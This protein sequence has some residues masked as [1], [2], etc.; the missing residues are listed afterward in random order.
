MTPDQLGIVLLGTTAVALSQSPS[1]A[2]RRFAPVFGLLGQPFWFWSAFSAHQP[3]VLLVCTL[4]TGAWARGLWSHWIA[5]WWAAR[6]AASALD[7]LRLCTI[8]FVPA[9]VAAQGRPP[10]RVYLAGPVTGV[11]GYRA[12]FEHWARSLRA[13]G[14]EVV[15]PVEHDLDER[16][17]SWV[18]WMRRGL[19]Q[20]LDCDRIAVMPGWQGSRGARVEYCVAK[21]LNMRPIILRWPA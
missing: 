6:G 18:A 12:A 20:L 10:E 13:S 3:G 4:Y 17:L 14:Y 19:R 16:S 9:D 21:V 11:P 8:S 1:D 15:S 2:L 5:P 7:P